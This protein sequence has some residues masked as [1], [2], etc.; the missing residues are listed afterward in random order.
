MSPGTPTAASIPLKG[1]VVDDDATWRKLFVSYLEGAG[2]RPTTTVTLRDALS[3]LD[4]EFFHV[5]MVDL[6]L[7]GDQ[8]RDG[9]EVLRRIY[10]PP[11]EGTEGILLSAYGDIADGAEGRDAGAF[12]VFAKGKPEKPLDYNEVVATV[13]RAARQAE[14]NLHKSTK[15]GL[16]L[17]A[18]RHAANA[19]DLLVDQFLFGLGVGYENAHD[20]LLTL[21]N[22]VGPF[23]APSDERGVWIDPGS[24]SAVID[25]WSKML[26]RRIAVALA[27]DERSLA[28][29]EAAL[30]SGGHELK[31]PGLH[32]VLRR[33][34]Q[35]NLCAAV[36]VGESDPLPPYMAT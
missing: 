18:G 24:R 20:A 10:S 29:V 23:T 30:R 26:G 32:E 9:L 8:N 16:A 1:L 28:E 35:R 14:D 11:R 13:S 2:L 33:T 31:V 21:L 25:V 17:L 12:H 27:R 3:L 7:V 5:A 6:S 4:R 36:L 22:G 15:S 19:P 34:A